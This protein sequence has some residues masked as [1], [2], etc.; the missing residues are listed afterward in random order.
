[1]KLRRSGGLR[2]RAGKPALDGPPGGNS[3]YA[4]ALLKQ[5]SANHGYEFGQVMTL[6]TEE[7][8]L[9]TDAKQRPWTN[10]SLR[11]FL[12]F[13]L[14]PES[15][16]GDDALIRDGRRK[17]LVQIAATPADLRQSVERVAPT[18]RVPLAGMYDVLRALGQKNM[19][20]DPEEIDRLLATRPTMI[21]ETHG[22]APGDRNR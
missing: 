13:G 2:G 7:V 9:S 18:R 4:A 17:L 22:R 12:N 5:L 10:G 1:M 20:K 15:Q 6:V 8:Y 14:N 19:P 11:R 21:A 3:P 16:A